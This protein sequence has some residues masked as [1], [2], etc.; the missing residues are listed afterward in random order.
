MERKNETVFY[1]GASTV[2][3]ICFS[4][5]ISAVWLGGMVITGIQVLGSLFFSLLFGAVLYC[6]YK[7]LRHVAWDKLVS[8]IVLICGILLLLASQL[9]ILRAIYTQNGWDV[10]NIY[11]GALQMATEHTLNGE[12]K[13]YFSSC[14]NNIFLLLIET[15]LFRL[16]KLI[17][18]D[19]LLLVSVLFSMF[20]VDF[21]VFIGSLCA[22]RLFQVRGQILFILI[23][24]GL[25][26][27]NPWFT[28]SYSDTIAMPFPVLIIYGYLRLKDESSHKWLWCAEM[29]VCAVFG[30]LLKPHTVIPL[31]AIGL[32]ELVYQRLS[33]ERII[34]LLR[35][36]GCFL[37]TAIVAYL[38]TQT[39]M[40]LDIG[41]IVTEDMK[42]TNELPVI[43]YVNMGMN[44]Y[45]IGGFYGEDRWALAEIEGRDK[46]AEASLASI[47]AR[48]QDY[49]FGGY[50]RFLGKRLST[51]IT[52]G[53]LDT[54]EKGIFTGCLRQITI[55]SVKQSKAY[56]NTAP[57]ATSFTLF[58]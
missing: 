13:F 38:S 29:G 10:R 55:P 7:Q 1:I 56:L 16:A 35:R 31:I 2:L 58:G 15:N 43:H 30:Y 48:L 12:F 4:I 9:T 18:V 8:R 23:S 42:Y 57:E 54:A 17:H 37:L 3:G 28:V 33:K 39:Y 47:K 32:I 22:K 14:P 51:C 19:N 5:L 27:Y 21:A 34:L 49:G 40:Y 52:T 36:A 45:T 6:L 44:P 53:P 26:V 41:S 20:M 11:Q 24:I 50:L 25:I 46:K